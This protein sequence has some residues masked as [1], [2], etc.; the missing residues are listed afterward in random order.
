[1]WSYKLYAYKDAHALASTRIKKKK[2]VKMYK[3]N[4]SMLCPDWPCTSLVALLLPSASGAFL[5]AVKIWDSAASK[6][7]GQR[8]SL[9]PL[10][11]YIYIYIYIY[12]FDPLYLSINLNIYFPFPFFFYQSIQ[13]YI[14]VYIYIYISLFH[15]FNYWSLFHISLRSLWWCNM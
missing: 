11:I 3:N 13:I 6:A 12:P 1:M 9:P 14:Y 15:T 4:M 2:T 8:F 5:F 10:S 7:I